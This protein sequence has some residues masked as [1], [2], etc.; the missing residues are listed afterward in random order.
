MVIPRTESN[1]TLFKKTLIYHLGHLEIVK[2][3]IISGANVSALNK[4]GITPL[5]NAA[6][7]GS[8]EDPQMSVCKSKK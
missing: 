4:G 7:N 1:Q 2:A 3:L 6:Q 5:H 8:F